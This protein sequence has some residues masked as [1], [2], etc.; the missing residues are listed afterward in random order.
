M[1]P[2][3]KKKLLKALEGGSYDAAPARL[4]QGC[5]YGFNLPDDPHELDVLWAK[6]SGTP[7]YSPYPPTD[8]LYG[9][10]ERTSFQIEEVLFAQL[11]W[12]RLECDKFGIQFDFHRQPDGL[13]VFRVDGANLFAPPLPLN[14]AV[15]QLQKYLWP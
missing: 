14:D 8:L 6:V 4:R 15:R 9:E 5:I 2:T 12:C 11:E 7:G 10:R 3:L 13:W 1:N